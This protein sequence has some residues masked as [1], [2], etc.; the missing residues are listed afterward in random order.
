MSTRQVHSE[1]RQHN[2]IVSEMLYAFVTD[3]LSKFCWRFYPFIIFHVFLHH[4]FYLRMDSSA[5]WQL[6]FRHFIRSRSA[7]LRKCDPSF[8]TC[9]VQPRSCALQCM[10][11]SVRSMKLNLNC[12]TCGDGYGGTLGMKVSLQN[13]L[14]VGKWHRFRQLDLKNNHI[15][16]ILC[17]IVHGAWPSYVWLPSSGPCSETCCPPS[18]GRGSLMSIVR[19]W[20]SAIRRQRNPARWRFDLL[21]WW[22]LYACVALT[23]NVIST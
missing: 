22:L 20:S 12:P 14:A 1:T 7:S 8:A 23:S 13:C 11:A 9:S 5:A 3:L 16:C 21:A 10:R 6:F 4:S 15:W 17:V 2:S 19:T 18:G